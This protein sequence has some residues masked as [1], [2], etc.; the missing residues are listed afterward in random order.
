MTITAAPL[1]PAGRL[2]EDEDDGTAKLRAAVDQEILHTQRPENRGASGI[3][4]E[5]ENAQLRQAVGS[6]ATVD[7]AI[8]VLIA[9]HRI[10]PSAGF[11]VLRAF[12][13]QTNIKLY[14]VAESVIGWARG[15]PLSGPAVGKAL[16]VAVQRRSYGAHDSNQP[17]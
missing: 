9:V 11:E 16:D 15:E 3:G 8:G 5:Q 10:P 1:Q 12:S 4:L 2:E 14:S 6:H 13:Q 17:G 7:Q